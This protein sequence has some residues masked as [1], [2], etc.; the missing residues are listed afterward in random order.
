MI[1][2]T[3]TTSP[4]ESSGCAGSTGSVRRDVRSNWRSRRTSTPPS[5]AGSRP[6][7]QPRTL[8]PRGAV[9]P[10]RDRGGRPPTTGRTRGTTLATHRRGQR[11]VLRAALRRPRALRPPPWLLAHLGRAL[12]AGGRVDAG[13]PPGQGGRSSPVRGSGGHR[14]TSR[15]GRT[16]RR[17]PSSSENRYRLEAMLTAARAEPPI[18]D[19]GDR[20]DADPWLLGVANGVRRPAHGLA[21]LGRIPPIASR[22]TPSVAFEPDARC[23]RWDRF[24]DEVFDGDHRAHRLH[25]TRRRL[26][27][28][29]RDLRA[30]PLPLSWL[31]LQRQER[32]PR[33]P[34]RAGRWLCPQRAVLDV[35]AARRD[36]ASPTISRPS[37]AKRS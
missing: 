5:A 12:V 3:R 30:V 18:A 33:G 20:W 27:P 1:R 25:P 13:P 4:V 31:G 14:R 28:H 7:I 22:C 16:R 2:A 10:G 17:S 37:P 21:P 29:R 9:N 19:A 11:R 26:Q 23:P 6:P 32:L 8:G 15:S 36:R 35:R 24:L 34:A